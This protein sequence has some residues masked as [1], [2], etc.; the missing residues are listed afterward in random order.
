MLFHSHK[1]QSFHSCKS[2]TLPNE[3]L[4]TNTKE[5]SNYREMPIE[6]TSSKKAIPILQDD[7]EHS[8]QDYPPIDL[9]E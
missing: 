8:L 4:N 7:E 6:A 1:I 3:S 2:P 5:L 9:S